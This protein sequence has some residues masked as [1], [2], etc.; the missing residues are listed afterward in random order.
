[1]ERRQLGLGARD[2]DVDRGRGPLHRQLVELARDLG[3]L[4]LRSRDL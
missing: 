1:L 4:R 3:E 2:V